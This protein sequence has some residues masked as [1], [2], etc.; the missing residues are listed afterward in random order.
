MFLLFAV[1]SA[2]LSR[3][4]ILRA[5]RD[6]SRFGI[7]RCRLRFSRSLCSLARQIIDLVL[8]NDLVGQDED[9][10]FENDYGG[11]IID[12]IFNIY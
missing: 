8:D 12:Y 3:R 11:M 7:A 5:V 10:D 4:E 9:L 2:Q 6:T 1:A